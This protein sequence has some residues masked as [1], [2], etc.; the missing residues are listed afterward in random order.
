MSAPG[1]HDLPRAWPRMAMAPQY[2]ADELLRAEGFSDIEHVVTLVRSE[3][4]EAP[5]I[6]DQQ[7]DAAEGAHQ[8]RISPVARASARSLNIRGT[9]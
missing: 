8:T 4:L 5:I 9:R 7:L 2:V 1:R 6:E 3:R